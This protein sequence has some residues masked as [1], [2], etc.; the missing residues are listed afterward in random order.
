MLY[1]PE[2]VL[3]TRPVDSDWLSHSDVQPV[4]A[5]APLNVPL[6]SDPIPSTN[7][8]QNNDK[9][10]W[11]LIKQLVQFWNIWISFNR[12]RNQ[13]QAIL[14]ISVLSKTLGRGDSITIFPYFLLVLSTSTYY[15][16]SLVGYPEQRGEFFSPVLTWQVLTSHQ[17]LN[18]EYARAWWFMN[19]CRGLWRCKECTHLL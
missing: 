2:A 14:E 11:A 18:S 9:T 7:T 10:S 12:F 1:L 19:D 5:G 6:L 8:W 3:L 13:I 15:W 4:L 16:W 17:R